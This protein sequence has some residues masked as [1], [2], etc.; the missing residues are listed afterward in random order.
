MGPTN[1]IQKRKVSFCLFIIGLAL[2]F[3]PSLGISAKVD[4][5]ENECPGLNAPPPP[6]RQ[7]SVNDIH[8]ELL[9]MKDYRDRPV[10]KDTPSHRESL[11]AIFEASPAKTKL[12]QFF[13]LLY[14]LQDNVD[15][16]EGP[17]VVRPPALVSVLLAAK[18]FTDPSF[19]QTITSVELRKDDANRP[20][21]YKVQFSKDE[22]RFP[23]NQGK[24]FVSWDQGMCQIAKELVFYPGFSFRIRN[25]R[26]SKNL[27]VDQFDKVEIFGTFGTRQ[28]FSIDLQYVDLE[29]VEFIAGTDEGKVKARVAQ[30]EFKENKHSALFRWV[31]TLIPNTTRQRIDW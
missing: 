6:I 4:D 2:A 21:I 20:P 28:M 29:K 17:V 11:Q 23:I 19:P 9:K 27:I 13:Q 1:R 10:W 3:P 12:E 31:G 16:D 7:A 15:L 8:K 22:V 5:K 26:N 25:A 24:G 30:R 14:I 18:V